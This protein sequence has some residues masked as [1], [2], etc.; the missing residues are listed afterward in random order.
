MAKQ[1]G[2][3]GACLPHILAKWNEG[4]RSPR[5]VPSQ[6]AKLTGGRVRPADPF[7]SLPQQP[8]TL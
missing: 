5:E 1:E 6:P 7:P 2:L 4:G 3:G 8:G